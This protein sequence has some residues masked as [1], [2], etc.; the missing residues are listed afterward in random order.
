MNINWDS[1]EVAKALV[2]C[3]KYLA[4]LDGQ[5]GGICNITTKVLPDFGADYEKIDTEWNR[6]CPS[7]VGRFLEDDFHN[8]LLN[9]EKAAI[10]ELD[11]YAR[12]FY[13]GVIGFAEREMARLKKEKGEVRYIWK[14][15]SDDNCFADKSKRT[16]D[17]IKECYEDMRN[18]ALNK[19]KW[20]TEFD[21]DFTEAPCIDKGIYYEFWFKPNQITL[22]SYSGAYTYR[23]VHE[24]GTELARSEYA[25]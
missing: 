17:S 3:K 4:G 14:A 24:D 7:R 22:K 11:K 23:I 5:D 19:S 8:R 16:F 9:G 1:E 20:N 25:K 12:S 18:A 2:V 15:E 6:F 13:V 21:E 10:D